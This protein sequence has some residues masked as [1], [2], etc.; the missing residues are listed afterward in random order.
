VGSTDGCTKEALLKFMGV[1]TLLTKKGNGKQ[2]AQLRMGF[3]WALQRGYEGII[4]LMVII[5]T[6]SRMFQNLL[7]SLM[8]GMVS[9]KVQDILRVKMR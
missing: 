2:G 5:K 4:T 9:F 3:W 7:K 8:K 6:A 1:N